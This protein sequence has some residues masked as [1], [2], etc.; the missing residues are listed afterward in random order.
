[1][2]EGQSSFTLLNKEHMFRKR[3][4]TEAADLYGLHPVVC[5][6]TV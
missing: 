6:V 3:Q 4:E 5:L 1:V 2:N